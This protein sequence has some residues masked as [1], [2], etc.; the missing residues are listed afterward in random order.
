MLFQ[1]G[2]CG[3]VEALRVYYFIIAGVRTME[4][5]AGF[6]LSRGLLVSIGNN[7]AP[8][9]YLLAGPLLFHCVQPCLLHKRVFMSSH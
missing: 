6:P 5:Y 8:L 2:Q 3:P 9:Y 7:E 4:R 1:V